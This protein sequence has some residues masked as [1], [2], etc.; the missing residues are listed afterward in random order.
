MICSTFSLYNAALYY[1]A[2]GGETWVYS[3]G[4]FAM[5]GLDRISTDASTIALATSL[6]IFLYV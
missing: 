6:Y 4:W 1:I 3:V 5:H 2:P